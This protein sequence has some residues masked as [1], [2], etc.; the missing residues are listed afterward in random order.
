MELTPTNLSFPEVAH[1]PAPQPGVGYFVSRFLAARVPRNDLYFPA[2]EVRDENG[3]II[4][5]RALGRFV[6]GTDA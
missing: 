5:C 2:D 4:G 3:R 1:L 6:G